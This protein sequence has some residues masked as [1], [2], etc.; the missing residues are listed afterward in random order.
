M[1]QN[2]NVQASQGE[3]EGCALSYG[4]FTSIYLTVFCCISVCVWMFVGISTVAKQSAVHLIN[5]IVR[6]PWIYGGE[7]SHPFRP[8][9]PGSPQG[10]RVPLG[11]TVPLNWC[12]ELVDWGSLCCFPR[13]SG[14][15]L[16]HPGERSSSRPHG[17]LS[18]G[19]LGGK[20]TQAANVHTITERP[21]GARERLPLLIR[22]LICPLWITLSSLAQ[23]ARSC[24]PC[25]VYAAVSKRERCDYNL[26]MNN[27]WV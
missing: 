6:Q 21:R 7:F 1:G 23:F 11:N 20:W 24:A 17:M 14:R 5:E 12:P 3:A 19:K 13:S 15:R 18:S 10:H 4:H 27:E 25:T 9:V 22:P 2:E 16:S 8:T 26:D